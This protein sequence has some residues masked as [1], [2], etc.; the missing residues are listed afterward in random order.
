MN[1]QRTSGSEHF[2][3]VRFY[4][5]SASLA[6]L[7]SD[8]IAHGLDAGEP[9]VI[10][11]VPDHTRRFRTCL[12]AK[13]IDVDAALSTGM[14]TF[15][16]ADDTLAMFM[17]DDAVPE[18]HR[19]TAAL[20]PILTTAAGRYPGKPVRAYGEMVDVLWK[21]GLTIAAIK[22]ETLWNDLARSH[23]FGLL[24]G[25]AIGNF[26]KGAAT[27]DI[28]DHHS[29]VVTDMGDRIPLA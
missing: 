16:D 5:D 11:A 26:Y 25:Y 23:R 28:C 14:L 9:G 22:L 27:D 10:I 20:D 17:R 18:G 2:H 8:F 13:G 24:C 29:H 4:Q 19:F 12:S 7:V 21:Q 15:L 1:T 3:A 6:G